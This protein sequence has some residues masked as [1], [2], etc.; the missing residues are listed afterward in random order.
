M[1]SVNITSE[2]E[3]LLLSKKYDTL[4]KA[5]AIAKSKVILPDG[6][7][8]YYAPEVP[9]KT[10]GP[11]RGAGMVTEYDPR[12]GC[13]RQWYESRDHAGDV[14]RVHPK[15]INGIDFNPSNPVPHYPY[16]FKDL[17]QLKGKK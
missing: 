12:T 2:D 14:V 4:N 10:S 8:R 1:S 6:R 17:Q 7:I 13:V 11:M 3:L 9:A 15:N 16:I 5:E